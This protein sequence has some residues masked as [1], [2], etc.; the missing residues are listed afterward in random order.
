MK[1]TNSVTFTP[2]DGWASNTK[3]QHEYW[4]LRRKFVNVIF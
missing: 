1:A 4:N 2:F 3:L